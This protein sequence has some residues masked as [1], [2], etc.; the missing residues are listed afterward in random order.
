MW[1]SAQKMASLIDKSEATVRYRSKK[2]PT[3]TDYIKSK[4]EDG[5]KL[6]Y[7]EAETDIIDTV[8]QEVDETALSH[9][10]IS[11]A[12]DEIALSI[13]A[14]IADLRQ[15]VESLAQELRQKDQVIKS[16]QET[17]ALLAVRPPWWK[18]WSE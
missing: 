5:R 2:E 3:E 7:Y 1:V 15:L 11:L 14:N 10:V 16:Q 12:N 4:M 6:Y 13:N 8:V 9:D 18:F 17:I